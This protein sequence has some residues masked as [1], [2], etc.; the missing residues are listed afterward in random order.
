MGNVLTYFIHSWLGQ[1][2][3]SRIKCLLVFPVWGALLL[4]FQVSWMVCSTSLVWCQNRLHWKQLLHH[5][6]CIMTLGSANR[7]IKGIAAL[8]YINSKLY[9]KLYIYLNRIILQPASRTGIETSHKNIPA[10][11]PGSGRIRLEFLGTFFS[12]LRGLLRRQKTVSPRGH[13]V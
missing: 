10:L 9:R 8:Q 4:Q 13:Q 11:F 1:S 7:N 12:S 2:D 6:L 5:Q 3:L